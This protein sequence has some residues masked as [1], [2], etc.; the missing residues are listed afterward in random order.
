MGC[1]KGPPLHMDINTAVAPVYQQ[2]SLVEF[3]LAT[4]ME[5]A[6]EANVK[7]GVWIPV[8]HAGPWA[9]ANVPV[10]KHTSTVDHTLSSDTYKSRTLDQ[11]LSELAGGCIYGPT[12]LKA[13]YTQIPVDG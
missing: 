2:S 8:N 6:I 13:A 9:F 11:V 3:S 1:Y 4:K 5:E 12:D 10:L 7:R